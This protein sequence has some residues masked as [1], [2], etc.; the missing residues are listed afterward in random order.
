MLVLQP[1]VCRITT[2]L[3]K[4]TTEDYSNK[5]VTLTLKIS[6]KMPQITTRALN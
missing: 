5:R 1:F 6:L 2:F 3:K 4:R